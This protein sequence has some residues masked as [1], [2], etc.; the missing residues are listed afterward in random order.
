M[1]IKTEF[2]RS[3]QRI[4][5]EYAGTALPDRFGRLNFSDDFEI[6]AEPSAPNGARHTVSIE[7]VSTNVTNLLATS[8][9]RNDPAQYL[10]ISDD[11][12]A[13]GEPN[14]TVKTS[15]DWQLYGEGASINRGASPLGH[16]GIFD[17][18]TNSANTSTSW[19]LLSR[20]RTINSNWIH[21]AD[22]AEVEFIVRFTPSTGM[23]VFIGIADDFNPSGSNVGA[24]R[25]GFT[26]NHVTGSSFWMTMTTATQGA[27]T[28]LSTSSIA[29]PNNTW[30]KL[31]IERDTTV[32]SIKFYVDDVLATTHTT[33]L[34]TSAAV[35][36]GLFVSGSSGGAKEIDIDFFQLKSQRLNR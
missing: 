24:H 30:T 5:L 14:E 7:G 1:A 2:L 23:N 8:S 16:P 15:L 10:V 3:L 18:R 29:L 13:I 26:Y 6:T 25:A 20:G 31:K 9:L 22:V 28:T 35:N 12:D 34:P 4:V 19:A 32:P 27:G 33:N 11:F 36:L 21:I 17:I